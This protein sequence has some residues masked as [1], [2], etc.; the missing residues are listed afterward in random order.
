MVNHGGMHTGIAV[1]RS[2]IPKGVWPANLDYPRAKYLEVGWG[3]DDGYRKDWTTGIVTKALLRSTRTVLLFDGFSKTLRENFDGPDYTIVEIKLSPAGFER[4]CRHFERTHALNHF[5]EPIRLGDDWYRG[6][7]TYCMLNT[8][9][10]W[11]ASGLR[12][13]GC[14]VTPAYCITP[15]PLLYQVRKFGRVVAARSE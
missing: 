3:D 2:D 5:G 10:T 11:V 12:S 7:G 8:C 9:N 15:V 14:P 6:R 13:A 4:L 1:K